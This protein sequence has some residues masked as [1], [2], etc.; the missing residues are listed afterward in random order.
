AGFAAPIVICNNEHRFLIE[1]QLSTVDIKPQQILLEPVARNTG[2]AIAAVAAWLAAREP[3]AL[4]LVQPSD[5]VIGSLPSFHAAVSRA[6]VAA[7]AGKFITFGVKATRPETGYG[8]IQTGAPLPVDGVFEVERFVEKPDR[9]KAER[10]VDSGAFCWN[11][12]IFLL[13]AAAY[14]EEL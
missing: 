3:D 12:G 6:L 10:F 1:E 11:S 8:Y 13:G 9:E 5:H 14:L 2:P 4:M 7:A